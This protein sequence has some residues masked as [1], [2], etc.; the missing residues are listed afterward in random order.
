[1]LLKI[2]PALI[3][4]LNEHT[5]GEGGPIEYE[6]KII[7]MRIMDDIR[8]GA[9]SRNPKQIEAARYWIDDETEESIRRSKIRRQNLPELF[10]HIRQCA[11]LP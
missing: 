6:H 1:M 3:P 8:A 7:G 4:R 10:P 9:R 5:G 2:A 11:H